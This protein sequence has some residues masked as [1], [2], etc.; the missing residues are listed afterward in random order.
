MKKQDILEKSHKQRLAAEKRQQRKA[1][2]EART[3]EDTIRKLRE[4]IKV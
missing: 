4:E 2:L 1:A 3:A